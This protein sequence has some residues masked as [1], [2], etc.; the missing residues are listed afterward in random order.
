MTKPSAILFDIGNV[1]FCD[2][3]ETLLLTPEKG[4]ADLWGLDRSRVE[5]VARELWVE[6]SVRESEEAQYWNEIGSRLGLEVS[7]SDIESFEKELLLPNPDAETILKTAQR[8]KR[9]LGIA[10]NNTSFW[11]AK[12]W[13]ALSLG[14]YIDPALVFVSHSLG[15]E[16][17][18]HGH[19]LLEY[20]AEHLSVNSSIL[21]DDR[22]ENLT[23]AKSLGFKTVWYSFADSSPIPSFS[24]GSGCYG[25]ESRMGGLDNWSTSRP[26]LR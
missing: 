16:K 14:R 26:N 19:G 8:S 6:F 15:V 1:L 9:P 3:W 17:S 10:S 21:V 13:K 7:L 25:D 12:Q 20:A 24:L 22:R 5:K 18:I 23:R 11:F 4:L 2:P